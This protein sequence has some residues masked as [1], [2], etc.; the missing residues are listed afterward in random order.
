ISARHEAYELY[1]RAIDNMPPDLSAAEQAE[2]HERFADAA[3]AIEHNDE[4]VEAAKRA[5][6]LYLA[7]NR[8]LDAA[9]L[10]ITMSTVTARD[11][12]PHAEL[13]AFAER[14]LAE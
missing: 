6:E 3:G 11:G 9:G 5:R 8:P 12:G 13:A 1:R 2:L 7:A 4:C 10:L 14:G